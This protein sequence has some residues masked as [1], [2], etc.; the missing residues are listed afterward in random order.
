MGFGRLRGTPMHFEHLE[1]DNETK[2]TKVAFQITPCATI[3]FHDAEPGVQPKPACIELHR[4]ASN[5]DELIDRIDCK[6]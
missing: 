6:P 1:V 5:G 3:I 2:N 4:F